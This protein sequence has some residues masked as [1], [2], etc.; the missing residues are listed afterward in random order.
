MICPGKYVPCSKSIYW[1]KSHLE[2]TTLNAYTV[3]NLAGAFFTGTTST[4][5]VSGYLIPVC[6][7]DGTTCGLV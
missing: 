3:V 2:N 1:F 7:I 5:F 4:H 6:M